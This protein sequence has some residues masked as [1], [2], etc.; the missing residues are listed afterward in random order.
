[1]TI[2]KQKIRKGSLVRAT[3]VKDPQW[4]QPRMGFYHLTDEE[5]D[6]WRE[7]KRAATKEAHEAGE[8]SFH[9]NFDS[10]GEPRLAPRH[11]YQELNPDMVYEVLRARCR[12][13]RGY[14]MESGQVK[15]LDTETGRALYC[16]RDILEVVG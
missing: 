8:D 1:M 6:Q 2:D 9:I 3:P 16:D 15:I 5:V 4:E 13:E 10:A 14:H 12:V 7:D 11:R